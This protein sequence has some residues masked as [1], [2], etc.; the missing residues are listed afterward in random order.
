MKDANWNDRY[1]PKVGVGDHLMDHEVLPFEV[2]LEE[3]HVLFSIAYVDELG[4]NVGLVP[5][6]LE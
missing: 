2:S 1:K 4:D 5:A 3:H 6:I